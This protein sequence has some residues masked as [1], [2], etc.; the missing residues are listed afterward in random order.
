MPT[1][2]AAASAAPVFLPRFFHKFIGNEVVFRFLKPYE[3]ISFVKYINSVYNLAPL[4]K[5]GLSIVPMIGVVT[6]KPPVE[7]VDFNTSVALSCTGFI[8]TVYA[9]LIQPQN[10]GSRALAV[11]NFCMGS[12]NG[13]NALR[14]YK[15]DAIRKQKL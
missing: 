11:V 10:A 15:Y 8:W 1:S 7:K 13:Y 12:V 2:A 6:G 4:S 3:H 14:R 9:L 5:W